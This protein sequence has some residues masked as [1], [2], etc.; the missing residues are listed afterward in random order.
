MKNQTDAQTQLNC[1]IINTCVVDDVSHCI[2]LLHS[3]VVQEAESG[4]TI[5]S[6]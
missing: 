2:H 5:L 4:D 6:S 1:L 3:V